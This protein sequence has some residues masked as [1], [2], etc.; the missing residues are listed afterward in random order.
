MKK[1]ITVN[2]LLTDE[3]L[4]RLQKITKFYQSQRPDISED[5]VFRYIMLTGCMLDIEEKFSEY[6]QL[7]EL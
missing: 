6:E 2:Y 4:Q 5:D 7:I 3:Q 1:E